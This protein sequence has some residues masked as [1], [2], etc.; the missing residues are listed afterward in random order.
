MSTS[1]SLTYLEQRRDQIA[2][3]MI[4]AEGNEYLLLE[5][6]LANTE[7]EISLLEQSNMENNND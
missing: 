5:Q 6:E 2:L 4:E 3:E 7:L 1:Q